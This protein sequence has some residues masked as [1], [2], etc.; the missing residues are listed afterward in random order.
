MPVEA[1]CSTQTNSAR[2]PL[3]PPRAVPVPLVCDSGTQ[4]S[5]ANLC[6]WEADAVPASEQLAEQAQ[7]EVAEEQRVEA[8]RRR[9]REVEEVRCRCWWR[10]QLAAGSS[11]WRVALACRRGEGAAEPAMHA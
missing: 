7:A 10:E 11:W 5:Q 9:M 6:D 1:S 2:A 8:L 3:P 4:V